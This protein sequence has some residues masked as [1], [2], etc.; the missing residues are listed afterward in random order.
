MAGFTSFDALISAISSSGQYTH[1]PF[2]KG[3]ALGA[4]GTANR[5]YESFTGA[6]IPAAGSWGAGTAGAA[7]SLTKS[8]TGAM[9][10]MADVSPK[11]R[12]LL[13][14]AISTATPT[15][16]SAEFVLMDFLLSYPSLVVTGTPTTLNNSVTLPRYTDGVGVMGLVAVQ[17]VLG[18]ASPALTFTYTGAVNGAAQVA[19]AHTSPGNSAPVSTLFQTN[20]GPYIQMTAGDTGIAS[21]QSYTLAS[22]TTGTA[23]LVLAKELAKI[24]V[25]AV[26]SLA[27][28]DYI[29]QL[30]SMPVI[31]DGACL[32]WM[33]RV[34][35]ALVTT[36]TFFGHLDVAWG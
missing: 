2:S 9:I 31:K 13:N 24:P 15:L 5:W 35:G 29:Y 3:F 34:G 30:G 10:P 4:S 22:G 27:E 17:T 33:V 6:G 20:G 8:S 11:Q 28:R 21:V 25:L 16:V 7:I 18:A 26:N 14:T 36:G 1:V 12:H 23:A 19:A 32:G